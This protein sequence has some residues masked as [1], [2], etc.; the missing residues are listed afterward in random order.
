MKHIQSIGIIGLGEFGRLVAQLAPAHVEVRGYDLASPRVSGVKQGNLAE[1]AQAD[2]VVLA[3]PLQAYASHLP[4]LARVLPT[5]TLLIDVCSVKVLPE[6]L[7]AQFLPNH[8]EILLTHPLFGPQRSAKE[9]IAGQRLIV[10]ACQGK[11]AQKVLN[12]CDATLGLQIEHATSEAHDQV[13]AHAHALT[14]FVARGL[15]ELNMHQ[16]PFAA[17]SLQLVTELM[18]FEAAHS[19]AL[20]QTVQMGNPFAATMRQEVIRSLTKLDQRLRG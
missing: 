3:I 20:F 12:F 18:Q 4:K 15:R 19:D 5:S 13:M 14:F 17:P 10:T 2:V 1:V 6:Q 11:R 9:G 16:L 8:S 7:F